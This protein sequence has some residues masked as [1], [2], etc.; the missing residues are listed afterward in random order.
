MPGSDL[1]REI[2]SRTGMERLKCSTVHM[3]SCAI[4]YIILPRYHIALLQ[5]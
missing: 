2:E 4:I 5:L 1:T 3:I